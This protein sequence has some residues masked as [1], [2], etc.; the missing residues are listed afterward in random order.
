MTVLL[1]VLLFFTIVFI[2]G[3]IFE[4]G[5]EEGKKMIRTSGFNTTRNVIDQIIEEIQKSSRPQIR[6]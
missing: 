6:R 1:E 3:R 5:K 2:F 4:A